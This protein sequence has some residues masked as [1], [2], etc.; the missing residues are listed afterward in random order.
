MKNDNQETEPLSLCARDLGPAG[1]A[2]LHRLEVELSENT[3]CKLAACV[4]KLCAENLGMTRQEA[5]DEILDIALRQYL[6]VK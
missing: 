5:R 2:I 6:G 4:A 3:E 1:I